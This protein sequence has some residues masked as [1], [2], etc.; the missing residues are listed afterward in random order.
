MRKVEQFKFIL[1][2]LLNSLP[3]DL[4][5][6]DFLVSFEAHLK[7]NLLKIVILIFEIFLVILKVA[8]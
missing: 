7:S 6:V 5:Q 4:R 3:L 1:M 8:L 2:R